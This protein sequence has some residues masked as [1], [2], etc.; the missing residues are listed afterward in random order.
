[1]QWICFLVF[2]LLVCASFSLLRIRFNDFWTLLNR[3]KKATLNDELDMIAG[4]PPKGFFSKEFYEVEQ[5]LKSTGRAEKFEAIKRLA[6]I[7]F[8]VG[9]ILALTLDNAYMIPVLGLGLA[10]TPV[11]YIRTTASKYKRRLDENLETALSIITTSYLRTDNLTKSVRENLPYIN[12]PVKGHFQAFL[13]EVELINANIISALNS[14]KMKIP[15]AIFHEWVNTLISCQSDREMKYTLTNT[16][17][18][19]SDIR[20]VQAELDSILSAPRKEA[21]TMMFLVISN[22]PLLFFLNRDWFYSL[23]FT[24]QGKIALAICAAVILFSFARIIKISKPIEY[25]G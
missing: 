9:V 14:L 19:F 15:S 23:V 20:I 4:K 21:V 8:V 24:F 6:I 3:K 2:I 22:I 25:R 12:E 11:W 17:Q 13:T 16:V 10:L 5:I 18:K 1:M 7:L